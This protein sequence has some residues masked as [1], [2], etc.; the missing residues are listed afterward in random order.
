MSGNTFSSTCVS[1][2]S[3]ISGFVTKTTTNSDGMLVTPS[4]NLISSVGIYVLDAESPTTIVNVT[5]GT[6]DTSQTYVSS[7]G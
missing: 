5:G 2:P 6:L 4:G 7:S 3:Y 1:V